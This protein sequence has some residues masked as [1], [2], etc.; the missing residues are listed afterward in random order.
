MIK[1][2]STNSLRWE[3]VR[4][5]LS[6][7]LKTRYRNTISGFLWVLLFPILQ[8]GAQAIAFHVV[9]KIQ[10]Q[11]YPLFLLSGVIP[12]IF[13]VQT[14]EMGIPIFQHQSPL[15]KSFPIHPMTLLLSQVGD[16]LINYF[17]SFLVL[18]VPVGFYLN[19]NFANLVMLPLAMLNLLIGATAL[20]FLLSVCQIFFR[21]T[22]F[23]TSFVMQTLF[24]LSPIFYPI[25]FVEPRW[26]WIFELNPVAFWLNTFRY[27]MNDPWSA[28]FLHSWLVGLGISTGLAVMAW[29]IWKAKRRDF[30]FEL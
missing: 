19:F 30:Y 17:A 16:N 7:N 23:V 13:L 18:L 28:E 2:T 26:R 6:A 10:V 25:E 29:V 15:L 20:A 24:F 27:M 14:I 21:D 8:Y 9:L 5:L 3:H 11:D 4:L 12:W 22:K 1:S